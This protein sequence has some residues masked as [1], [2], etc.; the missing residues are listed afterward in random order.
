M[1]DGQALVALVPL[2]DDLPW[3]AKAAWDIARIAARDGRRIALIDLNLERPVLHELTGLQP[4]E[5]IVDGLQT[6]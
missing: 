4:T 1:L 5:G 2:T 6:G 3:A